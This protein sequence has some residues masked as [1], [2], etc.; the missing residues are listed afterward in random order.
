[1]V[2]LQT[3]GDFAILGKTGISSTGDSAVVGDI[4]VGTG[5]S[6]LGFDLTLD[7]VNRTATSPLVDGSVHISDQWIQTTVAVANAIHYMEMAYVDAESR[8]ADPIDLTEGNIEGR[9]LAPGLY[10]WGADVLIPTAITLTGGADDVWIIQIAG[11]LTVSDDAIVTLAG[12]AQAKN[13][14]WQVA[15]DVTLGTDS[16]FSGVILGESAIVAQD[17]ATLTGRALSQTTVT[18]NG[19]TVTQPD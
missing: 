14:F 2:D 19:S 6:I 8:S 1:M 12:G 18:L 11:S 7:S 16:E 13:I 17:G 5:G 4:G 10:Q 3:A 9:N 15:D